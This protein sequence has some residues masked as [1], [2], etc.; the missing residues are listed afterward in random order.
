MAL[1]YIPLDKKLCIFSYTVVIVNVIIVLRNL[2]KCCII[3]E[4]LIEQKFVITSVFS[5]GHNCNHGTSMMIRHLIL[6]WDILY[7]LVQPCT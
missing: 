5:G 2:Y 7:A 6:L 3:Q 4:N 1:M